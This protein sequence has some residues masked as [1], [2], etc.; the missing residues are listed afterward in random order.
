MQS[1]SLTL[2]LGGE[3]VRE[4]S[5][6][7]PTISVVTPTF[8]RPDTLRRALESVQRQSYRHLDVLVCDNAADPR[9]ARVVEELNDSRFTY[10]PR[11]RNLGLFE[12]ALDG[13]RRATG[14]LVFK[15]DDDDSL[16][17]ECFSRLVEPF[18]EHDDVTLTFSQ[19]R[20]VDQ[21]DAFLPDYTR[22]YAQF[23]GKDCL[24]PGRLQPFTAEAA[25]TTILL[26]CSLV[27]RDAVDWEAITPASGSAYDLHVTLDAARFNSAA[28]YV[29]EPL[30]NYRVHTGADTKRNYGAQMTAA[31]H[32]LESAL[33]DPA[34]LQ[35]EPIRKALASALVQLGRQHI[36]DGHP[37]VA[38]EPLMR[39]LH[40]DV[41]CRALQFLVIAAVPRQMSAGLLNRVY[42]RYEG[43]L[44]QPV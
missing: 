13:F 17:P 29:P 15:L 28:F 2:R 22:M 9:S 12:N 33:A 40:Y 19:M 11:E 38:R 31:V 42:Q 24:T 41:S 23:F 25:R 43:R 4:S 3:T 21:N 16:E 32:V 20:V 27:R 7:T 8:N 36:R 5:R 26:A 18:R 35:K 14:D 1:A 34:H 30:V 6:G 37:E 39:S 44:S 10:L